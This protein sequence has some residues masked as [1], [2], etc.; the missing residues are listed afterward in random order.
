MKNTKGLSGVITTL[1]IILLV[2]AAIGII[3]A[4]VNPFLKGSTGDFNLA[5][6][7]RD[8]SVEIVSASCGA[9]LADCS[10]TLQRTSGDEEIA[11]VKLIFYDE[12]GTENY[13]HDVIGN[14]EELTRSTESSINLAADWGAGKTPATVSIAVYFTDASGSEKACPEEGSKVVN[15]A[16]A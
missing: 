13:I 16:T 10:V 14:I 2:I 3:W 12:A 8:T 1:I 15:V 4:V 6:K 7:C 5:N 9:L 11:G